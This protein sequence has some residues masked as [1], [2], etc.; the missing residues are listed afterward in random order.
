MHPR[1]DETR[2]IDQARTLRGGEQV[3]EVNRTLL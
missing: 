1:G 3:P 2:E